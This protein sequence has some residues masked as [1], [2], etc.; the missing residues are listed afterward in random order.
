MLIN[1]KQK[2]GVGIGVI[3]VNGDG[4]IL[5]LKRKGN[6]APYYSI[7]GGRLESGETFEEGA[8]R[9][10]KEETSLDIKNPKVI[11]VTNNLETYK[12]EKLHFISIILFTERFS[13]SLKIMEPEK[14]EEILWVDPKNLPT[15]H[16]D[17]SQRGVICYLENKFYKKFE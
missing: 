8:I 11:S 12:N 2:P 4:K 1:K 3:I 17:A 5:I 13:G 10:I 16:F 9:E 6:H 15:P 7:P 14:H